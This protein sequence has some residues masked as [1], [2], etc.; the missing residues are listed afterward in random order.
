MRTVADVLIRNQ[1]DEDYEALA[2]THCAIYPDWPVTGDE[3]REHAR[4]IDPARYVHVGLVAEDRHT[5]RVVAGGRYH[6]RPWS[7]RPGSYRIRLMVHPDDQGRGIGRRLMDEML[8]QLIACRAVL[9]E[10]SAR[11]DLTRSLAFLSRYR[12][13]ERGRSFESRLDVKR[14]DLGRFVENLQRVEQRG[15]VLTTLAEELKRWPDCLPAV[16][17]M[18]CTFDIGTPRDDPD[19]WPAAPTYDAFLASS[20]RSPRAL[21]EAYFLAKYDEMYVGETVLKR[22]D[23]DPGFLHQELTGVLSDLRGFGIATA[24]KVKGIEYAQRHHYREVQTWNSSKNAPML[25]INTKL[26]FV[27]KPAWIEFTKTLTPGE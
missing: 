13:T 2:A 16:Y 22:S 3:M 1:T 19:E 9:V 20:V 14:L 5:G 18:H 27:R 24:L 17:Q 10:V 12:F 25:A 26:G 8:A 21:H 11:E 6:Q 7:Y 23:A 15:I 4:E